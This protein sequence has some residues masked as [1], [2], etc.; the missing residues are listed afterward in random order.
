MQATPPPPGPGMMLPRS[1][2]GLLVAVGILILVVGAGVSGYLVGSSGIGHA[3]LRVQVTNRS[4]GNLTASVTVNNALAGSL[5]IPSDQTAT[6]D[7]PVAYA[8]S[9]GATFEVDASSPMGPHDSTAI[10]VNTPGIF[11]VSLQ[12][13]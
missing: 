6:L 11:V 2:F 3:T 10:L 1:R 9:N 12:L 13:G 8:T 7:V 4:G 5:S